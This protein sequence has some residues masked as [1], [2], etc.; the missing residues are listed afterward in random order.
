[1]I[2][3][4]INADLIRDSSDIF[5]DLS[6]YLSEHR[7][8]INGQLP[9]DFPSGLT[10]LG[11][12]VQMDHTIKTSGLW[13]YLSDVTNN[14]GTITEVGDVITVLSKMGAAEVVSILAEGLELWRDFLSVSRP[15]PV[16]GQR[17]TY[18]EFHRIRR[19]REALDQQLG[20]LDS[21]YFHAH[22]RLG[23]SITEYVRTHP[24]EFI[25]PAAERC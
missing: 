13:G 9:A 3:K 8:R 6:L 22:G 17:I 7:S 5:R 19:H 21:E 16:P 4:A 12:V 2:P 25:H 1:M 20:P 10:Q 11:P 23:N 15:E 24:H 18:E 14:D